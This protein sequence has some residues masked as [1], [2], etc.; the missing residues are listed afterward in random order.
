YQ[1]ALDTL[2]FTKFAS[3]DPRGGSLVTDWYSPRARPAARVRI[4][5][6]MPPRQRPSASGAVTSARPR[7]RQHATRAAVRVDRKGQED[8]ET[9]ILHRAR[10]LKRAWTAASS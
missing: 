8:L 3:E 2:Q 5:V 4:D 1:A 10:Q 9:K 6:F 7:R